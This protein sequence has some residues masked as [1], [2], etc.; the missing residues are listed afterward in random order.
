[1]DVRC[2]AA[3]GVEQ[4]LLDVLDDRR[5]LDVRGFLVREGRGC[6]VVEASLHLLEVARVLEVRPAGFRELGDG[7]HQLVVLD[8]DGFRNEVGLE[9]DFV[10]N[11]QVRRIGDRDEQLV[12]ALVER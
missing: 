10:Q 12:V 2:A 5:I 7:L 6:T 8:D 3:D 4:E 11:L 9:P 1:M